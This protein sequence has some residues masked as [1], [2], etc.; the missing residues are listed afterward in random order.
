MG[1]F[2]KKTPAP[3][4]VSAP[5]PVPS[6][7]AVNH[8]SVARGTTVNLSKGGTVNLTKTP[9]MSLTCSWP[10]RTDYDVFALV[11]YADGR[12]EH[13]AMFDAAGVASS[14]ASS[15]RAVRHLGDVQRGSGAMATETI[16]VALNDGIVAVV[17]VVYS[18]QSN[19]QGS[20]REYQ[21]S[22][23]VVAGDQRAHVDS[24]QASSNH[25]VY[26]CV[27]AILHH[28]NGQVRL[29]VIEAYS[30]PGSE[31]RPAL[32]GGMVYMDAGSRNVY[33]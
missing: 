26:S 32:R 25:E 24:T 30:Q 13:V 6:S 18:A 17:P 16:E 27:P 22:M 7:S 28:R 33:K 8:P 1:L 2:S 11:E 12:V 21:V 10:D 15:D 5:A 4:P 29:E 9:V 3:A 14:P 23:D 31:N 20:F 19:G